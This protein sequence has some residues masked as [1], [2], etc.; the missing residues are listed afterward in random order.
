MNPDSTDNAAR[1]ILTSA[2]ANAV[3]TYSVDLADTESCPKDKFILLR[4]IQ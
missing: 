3:E 1:L 2:K 4:N